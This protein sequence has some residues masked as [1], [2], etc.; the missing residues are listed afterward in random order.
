MTRMEIMTIDIQRLKR[1]FIIDG[2]MS[3]DFN[4]EEKVVEVSMYSQAFMKKFNMWEKVEKGSQY[5]LFRQFD[6]VVYK[7]L[8][9]IDRYREYLEGV[10][11]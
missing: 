3:I 10:E 8:V 4:E 6:D 5:M 7:T 2:L 11:F 1:Y 9:P